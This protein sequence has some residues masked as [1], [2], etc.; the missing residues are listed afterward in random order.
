MPERPAYQITAAAGHPSR[1]CRVF[2]A[3][4]LAPPA[5]APPLGA[6]LDANLRE[7]IE[8]LLE[9][10]EPRLDAEFVRTG[11]SYGAASG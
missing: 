10:G 4:H 8:L 2:D 1:G 5:A 9:D 11:R 3:S 6:L 7:V